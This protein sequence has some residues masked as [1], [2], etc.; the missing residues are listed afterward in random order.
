[1]EGAESMLQGIAVTKGFNE[2]L[3][4]L[5][6]S[7]SRFVDE[8]G[9]LVRA[10]VIDR[11]WKMDR[12]LIRLLIGRP[13]IRDKFFEHIEGHWIFNVNTFID[14]VGDKNFL[15]NSYTRFRNRIG[16][17]IDGKFLRERG[18][19]ALVWPYKDCVV[20]G[21][22]T[23]EEEKRRELFFNEVLAQDEI[24]RLFAPKVLTHW[25][26]YTREG[27]R[28]VGTISRDESGTIRENLIFRGNN[29]LVLHLLKA[30]F[31]DRIKLIYIDP[32]Y[33]T[34]GDAFKYNDS[35]SHS[36]WLTFQYNRLQAA[37]LLLKADGL[38]C[39]SCDD[40]EE[41][42]L[43]CLCD[44]IFGRENFI[45]TI[46]YERSGSAGLGQGGYFVDTTEFIL[47]Y[48]MDKKNVALNAVMK[49]APLNRNVMQRYNNVLRNKG[50]R[51]LLAEF[52]S[53]SNSQAVRIF[54]HRNYEIETI[55]LRNFGRRE[56]EIR[57]IY[58]K[59]FSRIFRTTNP[60]KEN[61]FQQDLLSRMDGGLY[62]VEYTPSRG[63]SKDVPTTLYYHNNELFAWL[64]DSARIQGHD[65]VKENKLS[66]F[67]T[68]GEIPKANLANEGGVEF[69]RGKK[70]EELLKRIIALAT[71]PGDI[72][73]DF[74][75][76]SGTT[77]AVAMK[78]HRRF[79]GVEQLDYG[80]ND[81]VE[82]LCRVIAGDPSG[83]SRTVGW[84]GGGQF[85]YCE[86]MKYN[87]AFMDRIQAAKT[88]AELIVLWREMAENSF[89]NWYVNPGMPQE[90]VNDFMD[91]GRSEKG[92]EKQK[93]LL[94]ELLNK[95]QLY[96][97]LSE[98][99]D[100]DFNVSEED[101]RM[102][103]LFYGERA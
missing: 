5:L 62:S 13:E 69:K 46:A 82:R 87:Q 32:P 94:A 54:K 98:M 21:G 23:R 2:R 38:I 84:Q 40:T 72:V 45:N 59:H 57:S 85:V 6:A 24:D 10:A 53:R 3:I 27:M 67:W 86:L 63:K 66:T 77:G 15:S 30:Q 50:D 44:E 89:L 11:A 31:R 68:H 95:N 79:I 41:A 92:L 65:V 51:E 20:E 91:I 101:K 74:F 81:S 29:L 39:I 22:Q 80:K 64:R 37:R 93:K 28:D 70:P 1:L 48:A 36:T 102:N 4:D 88:S 100:T 42:Y 14:F 76:G 103:R 83:I 12:E 56:P 35:F 49:T 17:N 16:L 99:D 26:R 73:L 90:A 58:K 75:L 8:E 19:V 9:E 34:G 55:S 61:S 78:C 96:V 60:Q 52:K 7:D 33:N 71:D 25:K 43:K 47:I 97:H 18:E